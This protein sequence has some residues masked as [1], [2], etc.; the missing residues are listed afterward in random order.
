MNK[1][2]ED[3]LAFIKKSEIPY[4][5]IQHSPTY[6]S[7]ESALARGESLEVGAKA[8]LMKIDNSYSLFVLSA[9]KKIDSKKIKAFFKC[10]SIRFASAEELF[11]KTSLVPGS[12]PPF[13][14]PILPFNLYVDSSIQDLTFVAFNA[15]SLS[16]SIVLSTKDYLILSGGIIS[17]FSK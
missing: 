12:V 3:L 6:T 1:V 4:Q 16:N 9:S 5:L 17:T 14:E 10:R 11:E 8:I 2:F 7:E 13:G 15:G